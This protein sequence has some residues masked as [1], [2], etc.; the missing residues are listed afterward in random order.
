LGA[1]NPE[2]FAAF[3]HPFVASLVQT[4]AAATNDATLTC[5]CLNAYGTL[6]SKFAAEMAATVR[7]VLPLLVDLSSKDRSRELARLYV[8]GDEASLTDDEMG[9]AGA[10]FITMATAIE[11]FPAVFEEW[12]EQVIGACSLLNDSIIP[13]SRFAAARGISLI[14][15]GIKGAP[16]AAVV[17]SFSALLRHQVE[18]AQDVGALDH[19]MT[20]I[21]HL[22]DL[23]GADSFLPGLVAIIEAGLQGNMSCF[24]DGL[25]PDTLPCFAQVIEALVRARAGQAVEQLLPAVLGVADG[26]GRRGK[27]FALQVLTAWPGLPA[28]VSAA[29]LRLAIEVCECDAEGFRAVKM[30]A[31]EMAAE[32]V[33]QIIDIV[34]D[35]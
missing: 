34:H 33:A 27:V 29:V 32:Q 30:L 5:A 7:T 23:F 20:A 35:R 22:V 24:E 3:L 15:D 6:L 21:S 19:A 9:V 2:K 17:D 28:D 14:S 18:D 4:L 26:N 13:Y 11:Q 31:K 10:A 1:G 8:G 12:S 25:D 16:I